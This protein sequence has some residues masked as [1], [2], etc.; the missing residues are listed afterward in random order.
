M[1]ELI[2]V[3]PGKWRVKRPPREIARS[4]LPLPNVISDTMDPTEQVDGKFYTSKSQFRKVGRSL[5]LIEIGTEKQKPKVHAETR[6][7]KDARRQSIK[8]AIERSL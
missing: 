2:E 8:N 4:D 6:A 7:Q 5:G 3:E 1:I